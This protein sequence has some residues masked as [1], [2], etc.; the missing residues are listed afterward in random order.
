MT[1]IEEFIKQVREILAAHEWVA[2]DDLPKLYNEKTNDDW[3][4]VTEKLKI[5]SFQAQMERISPM[6]KIKVEENGYNLK[7]LNSIQMEYIAHKIKTPK[8][9]D[10][11]LEMSVFRLNFLFYKNSKKILFI[12]LDNQLKLLTTINQSLQQTRFLMKT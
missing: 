3:Q 12:I 10:I 5:K 7:L 9:A 2:A 4:K 11:L 6:C 1:T 8:I